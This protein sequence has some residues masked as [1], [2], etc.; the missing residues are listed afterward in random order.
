MNVIPVRMGY[1]GNNIALPH[2]VPMK[3]TGKEGSVSIRLV[4]APRGTGIVAGPASKKVL[5]IAGIKDCYT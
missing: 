1:W 2:T 5:E 3:L 4:P